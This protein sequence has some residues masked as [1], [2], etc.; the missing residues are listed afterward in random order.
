[1]SDEHREAYNAK[2]RAIN[3]M[4]PKELSDLLKDGKCPNPVEHLI[5]V[6]LG[7]FHCE[8]CG[9]M[10]VAGVPHGPLDPHWNPEQSLAAK[11]FYEQNPELWN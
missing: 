9:T 5:G 10:V 7:M 1:M 4:S 8:I 11:G 3:A 6:P 2:V